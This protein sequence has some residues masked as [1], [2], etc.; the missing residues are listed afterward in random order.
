MITLFKEEKPTYKLITM[1][2][3]AAALFF[4]VRIIYAGIIA[5][6]Y[7]KELL[8]PSNI[9]LTD[10][11]LAGKSPYTASALTWDTP[12][13]N[14]DYPFINSLLAAAIAFI[15]RCGAVRAHFVI[16]L[17]SILILG[18]IGFSLTK[19][20]ASTTVLPMLAAILFMFC[21]WRFGYISAAPDDLGLLLML[22]T[23]CIAVSPKIKNK[24]FWCAIGITL[25]LYTKQYFVFVAPGIF[26][27]MLLY[28]RK[29]A[30]KLLA[31]SA[32][33]NIAVGALITVF[34]PLYWTK[35]FLLTYLG[36]A[37]TGSGGFITFIEQ[38]KYLIVLF[39]ALFVII[40]VSAA[41][42][43]K[44]YYSS[45]EKRDPENERKGSGFK[46]CDIFT[47][48]IIQ[49][50][51]ML[52]PLYILGRNDGAFISYFLQLWMT[53]ITIVA[54]ICF[55]RMKPEKHEYIFA[56]I[57]AAIA[58]VTVYFGFTKLP[59]HIL[60]QEEIADW[61]KAHEY[62][63]AA[64]SSGEIYYSRPLAYNAFEKGKG[65]CI[66][67]HDSEVS[68]NTEDCLEQAGIPTESLKYVHALVDQNAAYRQKIVKKAE[69]HTYS[70]IT[71]DGSDAYSPLYAE[72]IEEYGYK[73]IDTLN[74]Q[75]GNWP[76]E[77]LFYKLIP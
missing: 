68:E 3:L 38:F 24:A 75:L 13:V 70:L 18:Y 51:I 10:T 72:I 67:G 40:I 44:K 73:C 36:T 9:V 45:K 8:E 19:K 25:C 56:A 34:W 48:S 52:V 32:V 53:Y 26:I 14:Y 62:T 31:W 23:T 29:E 11:F 7:P 47:L 69:D 60:I 59:L 2:V 12:G 50:I 30:F 39:V 20:Y 74:L 15:T 41:M 54:L 27:Y 6:P 43:L 49:S 16:S 58:V 61:N 1:A 55:E 57:Y 33:I 76:Y 5:L 42:A 64:M 63:E 22:I 17:V 71:L 65:D 4:V 35:A 46:E 37:L 66:C 28:S 21:H 77:V